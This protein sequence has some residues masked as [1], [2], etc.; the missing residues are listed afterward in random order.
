MAK[1]NIQIEIL[2]KETEVLELKSTKAEMKNY[3]AVLQE[4]WDDRRNNQWTWKYKLS[5]LSKKKGW[6]KNEQFQRSVQQHQTYSHIHNGNPRKGERSLPNLMKIL[7]PT[8]KKL[9]EFK[10][11]QIQRN[12]HLY[13]KLL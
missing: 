11:R 2:Q 9:N 8:F 6:R 4:F 7:I 13:N 5:N 3:L 1:M 10:L 12:Q